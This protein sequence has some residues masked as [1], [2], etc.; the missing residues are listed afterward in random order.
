MASCFR[1]PK[2]AASDSFAARRV[3]N[4]G[5]PTT[6]GSQRV[7]IDYSRRLRT[8]VNAW[9]HSQFVTSIP[10]I[11]GQFQFHSQPFELVRPNWTTKM[12]LAEPAAPIAS[13]AE[14]TAGKSAIASPVM[15]RPTLPIC[16]HNTG[17]TQRNTTAFM[18][19][20]I[21]LTADS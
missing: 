21:F 13:P 10:T 18:L 14:P 12:F 6:T 19:Q 3:W 4:N 7:P 1:R 8:L 2:T 20:V 5:L 16:F 11:D 15:L 9:F 17:T